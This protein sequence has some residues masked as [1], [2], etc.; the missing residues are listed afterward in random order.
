MSRRMSASG[1]NLSTKRPSTRIPHAPTTHAF[2]QHLCVHCYSYMSLTGYTAN[3]IIQ[4]LSL[5]LSL[6]MPNL[7][8]R[9]HHLSTRA[10]GSLQKP[11]TTVYPAIPPNDA[12]AKSAT[13]LTVV[14]TGA[15]MGIGCLC[16]DSSR[17]RLSNRHG[18]CWCIGHECQ[19]RTSPVL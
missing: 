13:G 8:Q 5:T 7:R 2:L 9:L 12:L 11:S 19:N 4:L 17:L 10:R 16:S 15:G 14:I 1:E 18:R 6:D 3:A